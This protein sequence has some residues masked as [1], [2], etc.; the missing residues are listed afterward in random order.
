M[1]LLIFDVQDQSQNLPRRFA[2]ASNTA[3]PWAADSA[4]S[5]R[6]CTETGKTGTSN[7][8]RAL[9]TSRAREA[10]AVKLGV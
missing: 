8:A 6:W 2:A 9:A 7:S 3:R 4:N 1:R 5:T 10:R